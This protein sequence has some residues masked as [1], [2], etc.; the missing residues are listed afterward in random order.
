M[1]FAFGQTAAENVPL[2][3]PV[4]TPA[5][6]VMSKL[7]PTVLLVVSTAPAIVKLPVEAWL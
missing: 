6:N 4:C 7:P 2:S 5:S 3:S 1:S